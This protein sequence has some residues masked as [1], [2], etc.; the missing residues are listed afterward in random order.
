MV[1]PVRRAAKKLRAPVFEDLQDFWVRHSQVLNEPDLTSL[2]DV[3]GVTTAVATLD[4]GARVPYVSGVR[5]AALNMCAWYYGKAGEAFSAGRRLEESGLWL[6]TVPLDYEASFFIAKALLH[7]HGFVPAGRSSP[8]TLD[9]F[10]TP[11]SRRE[12]AFSAYT[13]EIAGHKIIPRW[14]HGVVWK[15]VERFFNAA[16]VPDRLS[17][18]LAALKRVD[19]D[20]ITDRRN[21]FAYDGSYVAE[22][23]EGPVDIPS[24]VFRDLK[25]PSK[26]MSVSLDYRRA[27][28]YVCLFR[29]LHVFFS[30][31]ADQANLTE[32]LD[33]FVD[34]SRRDMIAA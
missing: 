7:L 29:H 32:R 5:E 17:E 16:V 6:S 25:E 21:R 26:R 33:L 22:Q 10:P 2:S 12:R 30:E 23:E 24:D 31:S 15:I 4:H 11:P 18:D 28:Y 3:P 20:Q 9:I 1:D 19:W 13:D 8:V 34:A 14:E 27:G